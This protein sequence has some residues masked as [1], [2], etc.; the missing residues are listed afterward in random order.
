MRRSFVGDAARRAIK[1]LQ[2]GQRD[3]PIATANMC[4][5]HG[6]QMELRDRF[7]NP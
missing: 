7:D 3:R 2:N 5:D 4:Q 1:V 6:F